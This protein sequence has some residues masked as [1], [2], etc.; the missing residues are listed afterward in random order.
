[1]IDPLE[2]FDHIDQYAHQKHQHQNP[3]IFCQPIH[4][5][6][7]LQEHAS[8]DELFHDTLI[9]AGKQLQIGCINTF[10]NFMN[11]GVDRPEFDYLCPHTRNKAP[12]GRSTRSE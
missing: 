1:M 8:G 4:A 6:F 3:P 2:V 12:V 7:L 10:I 11:G 5:Y 9:H